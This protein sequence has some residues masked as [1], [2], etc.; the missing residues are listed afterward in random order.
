[1][2]L[3]DAL[4][5]G[6]VSLDA[7]DAPLVFQV[8]AAGDPVAIELIKWAGCELGELARCVIR[9]LEFEML[10]FD[11]VLVGSM[12]NGGPLLIEPLRKTILDYA[13]GARLVRL[14]AP[15]VTGA[16]LL[17]MEGAGFELTDRIRQQLIAEVINYQA[18][19]LLT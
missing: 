4:V 11:V 18:P 16:V 10:N 7:S 6:R 12:F 15:P 2:Q 17:G 13:P 1:M 14:T 9:Q 8:A 19:S 5:T 3:L